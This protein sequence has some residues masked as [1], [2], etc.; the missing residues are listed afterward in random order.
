M[1]WIECGL[2]RAGQGWPWSALH[3]WEAPNDERVRMT[4]FVFRRKLHPKRVMDCRR[5][6]SVPSA[7]TPDKVVVN[8][9][10]VVQESKSEVDIERS[11]S[12]I[13]VGCAGPVE[14][15]HP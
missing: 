11:V 13:I 6:T 2:D 9:F 7:D 1:S 3:M 4:T 15:L 5:S 10:V 8:F 14:H 12:I